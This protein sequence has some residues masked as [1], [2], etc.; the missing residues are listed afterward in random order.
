V[1]EVN[2]LWRYPSAKRNIGARLAIKEENRAAAL[3]F[4]REYFDGTR[5][6]GY[7]GYRYDGRW[8]K[9][10][11][12]MV[13]YWDLKP[14]MKVLDVGCAKGFLV[15]DLLAAC[16]GLQVYGVD[17][18]HYG[19]TH[20]EAEAKGRLVRASCEALPFPDRSFDAV[21]GIN[22]IHN[23]PHEQCLKAIREI[24]RLAPGR[25]YIQV[26]A[27]RSEDE[28]ALFLEWML[29]CKCFDTPEGWRRRFAKA[30]YTGDYYWT[31]LEIDE[32]IV[33]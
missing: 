4:D 10:A 32:N 23:L 19:L 29:T 28:R 26:D 8:Q 31:I 13:E 27:Y 20:A 33:R 21:I 5:E 24:E 15:K 12:D 30:G 3:K 9:I 16:P 6:Q 22:V 14:G 2:L 17:I 1:P 25:G 11:R 18:S 7:G